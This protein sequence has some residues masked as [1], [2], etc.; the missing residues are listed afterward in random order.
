VKITPAVQYYGN[1]GIVAGD[2]NSDNDAWKVGV[3]VDYQIV[4][5]FY[6]KATVN[7][8]DPTTARRNFGLLPPAA[9]IL[10]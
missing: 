5:N 7:Y 10:I 2:F 6:A 3:T 4:D 8:I 9:R 1:Y